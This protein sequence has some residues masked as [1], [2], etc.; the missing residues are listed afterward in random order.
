[1]FRLDVFSELTQDFA[2]LP[3]FSHEMGRELKHVARLSRPLRMKIPEPEVP[4][5]VD[6][7]LEVRVPGAESLHAA[8][9][10]LPPLSVLV[11]IKIRHG[12]LRII[13]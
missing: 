1:M 3:R 13:R 10:R 8:D 11:C 4:Q 5:R 12:V 6:R 2:A 9:R 7:V